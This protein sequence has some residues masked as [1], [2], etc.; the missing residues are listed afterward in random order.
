MDSATVQGLLVLTAFEVETTI[1]SN[2]SLLPPASGSQTPGGALASAGFAAG[3]RSGACRLPLAAPIDPGDHERSS[4]TKTGVRSYHNS[5]HEGKGE[6]TQ[7]L[8]AHQKK[9]QHGE[10][11]E[12]AGEDRSRKRLINRLVHH[13]GE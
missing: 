6:S 10:K 1:S 3:C 11:R 2:M 13:V 4:D 8:S 5:H 9:D 7:N 12:A